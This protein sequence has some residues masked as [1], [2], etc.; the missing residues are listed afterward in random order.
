MRKLLIS[1]VMAGFSSAL[2][3]APVAV[4]GLRVWEGPDSTRVVF[5]LTAPAEHSVFSLENPDRIVVD[6]SNTR[7]DSSVALPEATARV[8]QVRSA[9][10]EK[11]DLRVVFDLAE[12]L[13]PKSFMVEPNGEYG[14][15]LVLDLETLAPKS[16]VDKPVKRTPEGRELLIAVDAGHGGEDPGALGAR[17]TRE[18][19]VSLAIARELA[20]R[21][22]A[23]P[24]MRA[25]MIRDGDYYLDHG[26]RREKARRHGA[27]MFISVHADAF[28]SSQP[29][30]SSV[31]VVSERGASSQ[32]ARMLA[33][34]E[35]AADLVGGVSLSDKD[36][37]LASVLMDLSKTATMSASFNAARH[38]LAALDTAT[39]LHQASVQQAGLIVLKSPDVP[40]MLVE[41]GFISNATE[42][43]KLK[44]RAHQ[45][46]LAE[47][48]VRGVRSYFHENPPPGTLL[49]AWQ[50]RGAS[51]SRQHA[52]R[53][54]ET[55]SGIARQYK[56]S[57]QTLRSV[58][59]KSNDVLRV[60]ETLQIPLGS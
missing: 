49:A 47:A 33:E 51:D 6:L 24:G 21:I 35:N 41:T 52:V 27:D 19:D 44:D 55:L 59:G 22:N 56:V 17:G 50:G 39:K 3:A 36:D 42:E 15:R 43:R 20:A 2:V 37:L 60:G 13:K 7:M 4:E 14:H 28:T 29:S 18:K 12:K 40:S 23:E 1:L 26:E 57:L 53:S 54:G 32:A 31:Y 9:P 38:V 45:R 16:K 30:G 34:R 46:K 25:L 11:S 10:R 58:N 48:V 5:D 8:A